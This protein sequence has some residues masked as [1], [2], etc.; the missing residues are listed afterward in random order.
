MVATNPTAV[1]SR[2]VRGSAA[3]ATSARSALVMA[4]LGFVGLAMSYLPTMLTEFGGNPRDLGFLYTDAGLPA[5]FAAW[6]FFA[7][8][9]LLILRSA[10]ARGTSRFIRVGASI[11]AFGAILQC[12]SVGFSVRTLAY[13]YPPLSIFKAEFTASS[14]GW[15][16]LA[17]G[18]FVLQRHWAEW[19]R[20]GPSGSSSDA[21]VRRTWQLTL[22]VVTV[23][24]LCSAVGEVVGLGVF[25]EQQ[26]RSQPLLLSFYGPDIL[27]WLAIAV[28]ALIV[29]SATRRELLPRRLAVPA[30]LAVFGGLLLTVATASVLVAVELV[31]QLFELHWIVSLGRFELIAQF[32]GM[33]I[34]AT[35]CA[36]IA[37]GRE[38]QVR[39]IPVA[40]PY[41]P[42]VST[43]S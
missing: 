40:L 30:T 7:I 35:A 1:E 36:V 37:T 33:L 21:A 6:A 9:M 31:Y 42:R 3:Y 10:T 27:S 5:E 39:P 19:P 43:A 11:C 18:V 16:V 15:L 29:V 12:A 25:V 38:E 26:A 17:A 14:L 20:R 24:M 32:S 23:A 22:L 41:W 28:A 34:F 13:R 8:G 4:S 2:R